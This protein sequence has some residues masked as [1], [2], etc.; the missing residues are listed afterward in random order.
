MWLIFHE[1]FNEFLNCGFGGLIHVELFQCH[2]EIRKNSLATL[3]NEVKGL[4]YIKQIQALLVVVKVIY[5]S[6]SEI[7]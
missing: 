7:Q 1:T 2:F 5:N 6:E 3:K 4:V